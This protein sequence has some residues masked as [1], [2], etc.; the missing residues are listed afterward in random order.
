[1]WSTKKADPKLQPTTKT[2]SIRVV[3][4]YSSTRLILFNA[5]GGTRLPLFENSTDVPT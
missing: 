2:L 3:L 4:I 5:Q 1:M